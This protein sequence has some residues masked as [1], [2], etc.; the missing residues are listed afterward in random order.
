MKKIFSVLLLFISII[1]NSQ[2]IFSSFV[3]TENTQIVKAN[4]TNRMVSCP[5]NC[6]DLIDLKITIADSLQVTPNPFNKRTKAFYSFNQNDTV[7]LTVLNVVGQTVISVLTNSVMASGNY[8]DSIIMDAFADGMYFVNLKLGTRKNVN[9]K[10]IK[11]STAGINEIMLDN[12]KLL[13]YPNPCSQTL[14]ISLEDSKGY[15]I[16][17]FDYTMKLVLN[18]PYSKSLNIFDLES[19]V[20]LIEI[21]TTDN[22]KYHTKFIKE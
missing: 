9:K 21:I 4:K 6:N 8:Q 11:S 10:V 20:Y 18:S 13:I 5:P 15:E 12:K 17:I 1:C 22:H 16:N 14:S 7:S 19:G 2:N 3:V